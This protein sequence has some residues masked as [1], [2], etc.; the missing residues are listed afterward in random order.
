MKFAVWKFGTIFS[1]TF[2]LVAF[3]DIDIEHSYL[4]ITR[5]ENWPN[6]YIIDLSFCRRKKG[7]RYYYLALEEKEEKMKDKEEKEGEKEEEE[8]QQKKEEEEEE[9]KGQGSEVIEKKDERNGKEIRK[10]RR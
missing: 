4:V 5:T 1:L 9:I 6:I 7:R 8:E 3:L 2:F 10:R